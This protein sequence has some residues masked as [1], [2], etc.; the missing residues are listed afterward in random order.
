MVG[1]GFHENNWKTGITMCPSGWSLNVPQVP[2]ESDI[3]QR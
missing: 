1:L 3:E 2:D